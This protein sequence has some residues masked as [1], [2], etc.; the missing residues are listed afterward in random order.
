MTAAADPASASRD[1]LPAGDQFL[2]HHRLPD[3]ARAWAA[4]YGLTTLAL[5]ATFVVARRF[6]EARFRDF[7]LLATAAAAMALVAGILTLVRYHSR[8]NNTLLF[9]GAA[10][11][12]AGILDSYHAMISSAYFVEAFPTAPARL[13]AWSWTISRLFLSVMLL[14]SWA[15]GIRQDKLGEDGRIDARS[16]YDDVILLALVC[17]GFFIVVPLP[18]AYHAEWP[19]SRPHALGVSAVF[20]L[21]LIGYLRRGVW[22]R[23][24][25]EKWL[26][27]ALIVFFLTEA[28]F[29]SFSAAPYDAMSAIAHGLK[30]LAYG[31]ILFGV[32]EST[33]RL[34]RTVEETS[35]ELEQAERSVRDYAARLQSSNAELEQFAY[36]ASHDLQEPLRMIGGYTRLLANKYE[37]QLDAQADLYIGYTVDG[38]SRMQKL[39]DDLLTYSRVE[40]HGK[41]FERVDSAQAFSWATTNLAAVIEESGASITCD[42][43]PQVVAE[44]TQLGQLFQNLISNAIKYG[45]ERKPKVHASAVRIDDYW[46]F[47]VS[48][49]GIGIAAEDLDHVFELFRRLD[50]GEETSGTGIGLAVCKR[51]VDRH[52]GRIWVESTPG[53]GST[54]FFTLPDADPTPG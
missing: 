43:L 52:G 4:I 9:I 5:V 34:F 12:G 23:S 24:P 17:L 22:R 38:V 53:E 37:G 6:P 27:L 45:G 50:S 11:I 19:V 18:S 28:L 21:A 10:L 16:I 36:A 48:D 15:A 8:P 40:T 33:Y 20:V 29:V 26:L 47:S 42:D 31:A 13:S 49:N 44:P 30:V 2:P 7:H 25:F 32:V 35:I 3:R 1:S 46:R 51:I 14:A 41:P 54:F 39:I